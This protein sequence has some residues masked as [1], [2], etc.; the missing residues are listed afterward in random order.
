MQKYRT[1]GFLLFFAGFVLLVTLIMQPIEIYYG[2]NIAF[3]FPKGIIALRERNLLF[4]IQILMLLV[5]IPVYILTF[6]FSWKYHADNKKAKYDPKLQDSLLAE[7]IWWS[8]PFI[9]T[10]IIGALTWVETYELDPYK[11]IES[12][13]KPIKIQVVALQWKWLFLYPEEKIATVNFLQVPEKTPIQF[14]LTSDAPMN[15]FWIPQLAGQIYAMPN[16]KTKLNIIADTVGEYRGSSANISGEGFSGMHFITKVTSE[17]DYNQ[18]VQTSKQ[19]KNA[20]SFEEYQNLAHPSKDNPVATYQLKTEN[21]FDQIFL[22][23]APPNH[24]SMNE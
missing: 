21:L 22:K 1:A 4:F 16:M 2:G 11:P 7:Y 10:L 12:D 18:W 3:L 6:V 14:E 17:E 19:E 13:K 9:I 5:V 20:L 8:F 24:Q 23:Y 15:S